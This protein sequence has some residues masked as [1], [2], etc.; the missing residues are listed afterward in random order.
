M[1][2]VP[3][4]PTEVWHFA[5]AVTVLLL[6][7]SAVAAAVASAFLL[8]LAGLFAEGLPTIKAK[9]RPPLP[10]PLPSEH[11]GAR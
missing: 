2:A 7:V 5:L 4:S 1:D 9:L 3:L 8:A 11:A 10:I 6:V